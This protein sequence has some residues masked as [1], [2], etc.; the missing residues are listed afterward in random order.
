[1]LDRWKALCDAKRDPARKLVWFHA[2]SVGEGLQ[3]RPIVE[4]LR[5]QH[6]EFQIAYSFF[7]PSAEKFAA[8]LNVD[9][10]EYLPFDSSHA[11]AQLISILSP[12]ALFFSK[13]DVWPNLVRVA[14]E[15]AVTTGLL[16]A[17]LAPGSGRQGTLARMTLGDAYKTLDVVGAIDKQNAE[18]LLQLGVQKDRLHITGDTRFDQ[19]WARAQTVD[20]NSALIKALQSSR[21]TLVAGS[22]WPAD[23]AVLLPAWAAC[24]KFRPDLR[25][26]IAPHE[27]TRDHLAPIESW[28]NDHSL[29]ALALSK[30]VPS[31]GESRDSIAEVSRS[32]PPQAESTDCDVVIVDR[33]G[34]LGSIYAVGNAAF[35]GGGFHSAGLHSVI[36]PAAFGLPVLFGPQFQNSR[37]AGLLI[38]NGAAF[39]VRAQ[40][41]CEGML[42]SIF[43]DSAAM[44][45]ARKQARALVESERG[46]SDRSVELVL[47]A[48]TGGR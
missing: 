6:P 14:H 35:V 36:E 13:L 32:M 29:N 38:E 17:T 2:P 47:R 4:L 10:A 22:T 41:D 28:A 27:P 12:S 9:I 7:S 15:R 33:V 46:A 23:E 48:V 45:Q 40:S 39:S 21:P 34:V 24:K 37:E 42:R 11:A 25:L 31:D 20:R 44:Q 5:E 26:I 16:S 19:V 30:L 1:M 3:A 43:G 8:S 18:R